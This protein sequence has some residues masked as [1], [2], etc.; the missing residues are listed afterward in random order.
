MDRNDQVRTKSCCQANVS[1]ADVDYDKEVTGPLSRKV[2]GK[3]DILENLPD[4]ISLESGLEGEEDAGWQILL[5]IRSNGSHSTTF[6]SQHLIVNTWK[7]SSHC[8]QLR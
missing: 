4:E 6:A 7:G 3:R 2:G 5:T 8:C 1:N